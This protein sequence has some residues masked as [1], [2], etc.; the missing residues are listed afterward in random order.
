MGVHH[1]AGNQAVEVNHG[2]HVLALAGAQAVDEGFGALQAF[3]FRT[4]ANH[5]QAVFERHAVEVTGDFGEHAGA[6]TVVIQALQGRAA[7]VR[8]E[9]RTDHHVLRFSARRV[10]HHI[11][12]AAAVT[13]PPGKIL[14]ADAV[15][16][17]HLALHPVGGTGK[18]GRAP[19]AARVLVNQLIEGSCGMFAVVIGMALG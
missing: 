7:K 13:G 18:V 12:R 19:V 14:T 6:R 5:L 17:A 2:Q 3:F 8:V 16:I 4:K 10:G 11:L 1:V 15:R 9:M